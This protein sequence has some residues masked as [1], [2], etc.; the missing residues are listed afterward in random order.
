M[1]DF[2]WMLFIAGVIS[3]EVGFDFCR[4]PKENRILKS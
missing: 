3:L 4:F 1:H 2:D